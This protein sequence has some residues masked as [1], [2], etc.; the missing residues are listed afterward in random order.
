M[1][2][3]PADA[4]GLVTIPGQSP[5]QFKVYVYD[6]RENRLVTRQLDL[7]P[8]EAHQAID[9]KLLTLRGTLKLGKEPLAAKLWFG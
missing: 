5:G 4:Q 2:D 3:G 6:S 7:G 9:L 8:A 1:Y